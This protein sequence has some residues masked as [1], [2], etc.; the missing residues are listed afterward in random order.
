MTGSGA[1]RGNGFAA[2]LLW[3]GSMVASPVLAQER[4]PIDIGPLETENTARQKIDI[5]AASPPPDLPNAAL[6]QECEDRQ[7][8]GVVAGEI[9][10]CRQLDADASQFYSGSRADW[11]RG[12]AE[13]TQ[14]EGTIP[15]PDVAGPG[16]FRG[17]ATISGMCFIPPCPKSSALI[18][19]VEAIALPPAGSDAERVAQGL[20][21]LESDDSP[22]A[23]ENRRRIEA[24][25]G[26]PE[27]P[28][29]KPG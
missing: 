2:V 3:A 1:V 8:A 6:I 10:V 28:Q 15:P 21:P 12:F 4:V 26:L 9:V 24:E 7:E 20:A 19:N 16:I 27:P 25:L 13:R 11:L 23:P 18:V 29:R 17:P 22:L 5:L 14:G